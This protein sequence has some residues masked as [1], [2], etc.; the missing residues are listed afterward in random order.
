MADKACQEGWG[1]ASPS[2]D[3]L[4]S[5]F[6]N[7]RFPFSRTGLEARGSRIC[8]AGLRERESYFD[9][10]FSNLSTSHSGFE[11]HPLT[12]ASIL[13]PGLDES[14]SRFVFGRLREC[15]FNG[16]SGLIR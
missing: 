9:S 3:N 8:G 2:C 1:E 15:G 5:G 13:G 7:I 10:S 12:S 6:A 11:S 4:L 14:P 16:V